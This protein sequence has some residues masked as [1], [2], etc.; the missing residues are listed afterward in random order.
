MWLT[1]SEALQRLGTKPQSLYASVSRGRVAAKPD[2]ADSRKSL[3]RADD[4]D[5][6][7][8][9]AKGRSRVEAMAAETMNWGQPV[10]P[11]AISTIAGGRLFYRGQDVVKL[12][13]DASLE[14]VASLLWELPAAPILET[15]RLPVAASLRGLL[16]AL[17][18]RVAADPPSLSRGRTML[19]RDATGLFSL[20]ADQLA[21]PG[22]AALHERLA[23]HWDRSEAVDDLRRALVLLADHEMNVST[24]GAR[25]T[26][27]SGASLAAGMLSGLCALSGPLHGAAAASIMALAEDVATDTRG[28]ERALRDW[29]GEGRGIPGFGHR[30]YPRGDVRAKALLDGFDVPRPYAEF[31]RAAEALSGEFANVDFALA[32][33]AAAHGL[34]SDAPRII[35]ALARSVGWLAHM[36]EQ[37]ASGTL[38]RPRAHYIGPSTTTA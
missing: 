19:L 26:V 11:S 31:R 17:A 27:S 22:H 3:Y 10:L 35:F 30:L 38:I 7:A 16:A 14:D 20:V 9:R 24:F 23:T 4:I 36:L 29:V 15:Q 33:L 2:P 32:A 12:A 18:E 5:R 25:V 13:A 6:L 28:T 1:A 21:G 37:A 34:S 8:R